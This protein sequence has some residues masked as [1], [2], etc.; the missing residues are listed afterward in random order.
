[1]SFTRIVPLVLLLAATAFAQTAQP[2]WRTIEEETMRHFQ[3]ILRLDTSNPPG[4]EILVV[5]YLKGVL[6][7]EGIETRG[8][9]PG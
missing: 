8:R 6:E 3:A 4:N 1:M 9:R 5:E 2:D 7:R